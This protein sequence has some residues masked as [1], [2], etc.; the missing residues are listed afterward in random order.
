MPVRELPSG[1]P[2]EEPLKVCA[3]CQL[4][5]PHSSFYPDTRRPSGLSRTC[6]TCVR[7]RTAAAADRKKAARQ[8]QGPASLVAGLPPATAP[9][10]LASRGRAPSS[11]LRAVFEEQVAHQWPKLAR[12]MVDLAAQGDRQML[13]LVM[14][15]TL[16]KPPESTAEDG[17]A[18]FWQLVLD[19]AREPA[20]Q[21][22]PDA[23]AD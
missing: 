19:A 3:R 21:D 1:Q 20:S 2:G 18:D 23:P 13:R 12:R 11:S 16:G 5:Q 8:A 22:E 17:L 4:P 10:P 6:K 14:A 7:A 9:A 15:Y